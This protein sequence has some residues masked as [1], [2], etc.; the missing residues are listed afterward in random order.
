MSRDRKKVNR[1][2]AK[3]DRRET[4]REAVIAYV[5]GFNLYHGLKDVNLRRGYWLDIPALCRELLKPHQDLV[6][7]KYFTARVKKPR[8]SGRRQGIYL[9]ALKIRGG[10]RIVKG[11][12]KPKEYVCQCG[13]RVTIGAEKRTDVN[14]AVEMI[15]DA[16]QQQF[17][18]AMLISGDTDF[19][20][21]MKALPR[22]YRNKRIIVAFPPGRYNA[23]SAQNAS[24]YVQISK[25]QIT[26]CQL[27]DEV[28]RS[29]GN[30]PLRRPETWSAEQDRIAISK[31][32]ERR[33][34]SGRRGGLTGTGGP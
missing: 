20:G 2:Q 3:R 28:P 30:P 6:L 16:H 33:T 8:E 15:S 21:L 31:Q 4:A 18:M 10:I 5:D 27:P 14:I 17:D 23:E 12:H 32:K 9:K 34:R 19:C 13:R 24:G 7:V 1:Q 22:L 26:K 29:D 25:S 11:R